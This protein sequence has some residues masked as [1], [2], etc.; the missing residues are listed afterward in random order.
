[1]TSAY[2]PQGPTG[3]HYLTLEALE[4]AS[5]S[6]S[7]A[8]CMCLIPETRVQLPSG[9]RGQ[10]VGG[11]S[12]PFHP[13]HDLVLISVYRQ[14]LSEMGLVV[15]WGSQVYHTPASEDS[16]STTVAPGNMGCLVPVGPLQHC[17]RLWALDDAEPLMFQKIPHDV[18]PVSFPP[19]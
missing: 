17:S 9:N 12:L 4:P 14:A 10:R 2:Y 6:T 15:A 11:V 19:S 7:T 3:V 5:V 13:G 8:I 16:N 1:M 18:Q